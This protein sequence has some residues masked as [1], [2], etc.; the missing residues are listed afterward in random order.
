[1]LLFPIILDEKGDQST[2][3]R[4]YTGTGA[5]GQAHSNH[6]G[7]WKEAE[8]IQGLTGS[9]SYSS[10][11]WTN[12]TSLDCTT[13]SRLYCFGI[14]RVADL[15]TPEVEG[16][17]AF[18]SDSFFLPGQ[19]LSAADA[20][21]QHD[22]QAAGLS[23]TFKAMIA[24]TTSSPIS[25]FDT[26]VPTGVRVDG[27]TLWES[28]SDAASEDL[29]LP[30]LLTASRETPPNRGAWLGSGSL[31]EAGTAETTCDDWTSDASDA[32]ARVMAYTQIRP[33]VG[34]TLSCDGTNRRLLCFEE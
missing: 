22:A 30:R 5:Q 12:N 13:E 31:G 11:S 16:R 18:L 8:G 33:G 7:D 28:A 26:S 20:L 10:G 3:V 25:R 23:G 1:R 27:L 17:L 29:L 2:F 9:A 15:P 21:C 32:K 6:C 14:D 34:W 4:V 24:T 19:D